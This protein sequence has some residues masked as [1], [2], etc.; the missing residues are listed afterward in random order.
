MPTNPDSLDI[1]QPL[2]REIASEGGDGADDV[3]YETPLD[4]TED[5]PEVAGV[6]FV[7]NGDT[8]PTRSRAIWPDGDDLRFRDITNP[9]PSNQGFTLTALLSGG[10][11]TDLDVVLSDDVTGAVLVD[12]LTGN[13]LVNL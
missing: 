13:I 4:P 7:D 12:D 5:A 9:G 6:F 1:V 10:S 2:K 3:P 11:G 8:R